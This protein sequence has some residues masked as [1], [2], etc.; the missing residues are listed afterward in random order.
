MKFTKGCWM[1]K[2]G[3]RNFDALQVREVRVE[4]NKVYLYTVPNMNDRRLLGG[5][6]M[7]IYISSPQPN[8]IRTEAYHF[9]GSSLK[10]PAYELNDL[11][12]TLDV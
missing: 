12:V 6:V 10:M 1:N 9:M 8:I 7:E 5:P 4:G 11:K 2:D 3:V